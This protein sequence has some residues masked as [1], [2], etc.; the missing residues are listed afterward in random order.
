MKK[1]THLFALAAVFALAGCVND[2]EPKPD[3]E[4]RL[5]TISAEVSPEGMSDSDF[6]A[7]STSRLWSKGDNIAVIEGE[8]G[9][10]AKFT[11]IPGSSNFSGRLTKAPVAAVTPYSFVSEVSG[12]TFS[13][14]IPSEIENYTPG[15]MIAIMVAEEPVITKASLFGFSFKTVAGILKFTVENVPVGTKVFSMTADNCVTGTWNNLDTS[16]STLEVQNT[17]NKTIRLILSE[18]VSVANQTMDFYVPVPTGTYRALTVKL[19]D[20]NEATLL[21]ESFTGLSKSVKKNTVTN[22]GTITGPVVTSGPGELP[23]HPRLYLRSSDIPRIAANLQTAQGQGLRSSIQWQADHPLSAE[24]SNLYYYNRGLPARV[25]LEALDYLLTQDATKAR[26]AIT[27]TLDTLQ[28]A[29]FPSGEQLAPG[30]LLSTGAMVYDWCYDQLTAQ[31]KSDYVAAFIRVATNAGL[32]PYAV[33]E[34]ITGYG[35][36]Y[37][38]LRDLLAVAIAIYDEY[39]QMYN[40]VKAGFVE[41]YVPPRNFTY[42]AGNFHQGTNYINI[43]FVS[44]LLSQAAFMKMGIDP[45]YN[46]TQKNVLYDFI[47]RRRPDGVYMP[48]GDVNPAAG[49]QISMVAH[50]ASSLYGDSYLANEVRGSL[51]SIVFTHMMIHALVLG[52]F[53]I[54]KTAPDNLPLTRFSPKPFGWMIARTGWDSNSAIVEMK[55][56]ENMFANHQ[57]LDGGAFQIYYKGPLAID[58]GAYEG[59]QGGYNSDHNKKYFKRTIAHNSLLLYYSSETFSPSSIGNDGGQRTPGAS[60]TSCNSYSALLSDDYTY[61]ST[62][63]HGF[64]P[65]NITPEYSY[66]KG[67]ITKAYKSDKAGEV[68]RSFVFF[69]TSDA[70]IPGVLIVRDRITVKKVRKSIFSTVTPEK[71]WLLHSVQEPVISGS[72]FDIVR[73]GNDL[74]NSGEQ[75]N[76]KLHCDV[77]TNATISKVGGSGNEF[78]VFG[79]NYPNGATSSIP[80]YNNEKG[81]WRIQLK[82]SGSNLTDDFLNVIQ[83]T[84][85]DNTSYYNVQKITATNVLGAQVGNMA[86]IFSADSKNLSSGSITFSVNNASASNPVKVLV[87]DLAAGSWRVTNNG[88][89]TTMTVSNDEHSLYFTATAASCT[90]AKQ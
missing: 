54:N 75:F 41:A 89:S 34:P 88:S 83:I 32:W 47:Y 28:R 66:L 72:T 37:V 63:A 6:E 15:Q 77:L 55:V 38:Y 80:D 9:D 45:L 22:I 87:T 73:E 43:R 57:H 26:S 12:S 7:I 53:S 78:Y 61:G 10:V 11:Y 81:S 40:A 86:A 74:A 14:T 16:S 30:M 59:A 31:E 49:N 50:F 90:I 19:L 65:S 56:N 5:T 52:D 4:E 79:T 18:A 48:A 25:Q 2:L 71:Y 35:S 33:S 69:N 84:D 20:S 64:G 3:Q 27:A 62:L 58:S 24:Q 70:T 8:D 21:E 82:A 13:I 76:G 67:D 51:N 85:A 60:W 36:E 1:L 23:E 44:D 29:T 42:D 68:L 39:P 17:G 46:V